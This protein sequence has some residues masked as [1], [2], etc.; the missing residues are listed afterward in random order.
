MIQASSVFARIARSRR[1]VFLAVLGSS[2]GMGSL[3]TPL[4]EAQTRD[5]TVDVL[6]NSTNTAGYNTSP[7]QPGEYQRYPERY[8]ENLQIPYRVI[9][10]S[11]VNPPDLTSAQ[12]II[13]GHKGLNL[14]TAWQ[15]AIQSAVVGGVGFVNLDSD[16]AVGNQSHIQAIF[17]ATGSIAGT[18]GESIVVPAAVQPGGATPHYIAGMQLHFLSDPAGDLIYNF[19]GD[20]ISSY[21]TATATL[22]QG[23]H[24]AVVAYIHSGAHS[25]NDPLILATTYGLGSA[26]HFGTYDYLRADRFGFN[27]GVDDL[28]WRSLV[29]AARKP[30]VI[31]AY[32]RLFSLQLD[33]NAAI[34]SQF[35][36]RLQHFWDTSLTGTVLQDGTGG[37]WKLDA[38]I[39]PDTLDPGS[40]NSTADRDLLISEI[41]AGHVKAS[42]HRNTDVYAGDLFWNS[43]VGPWS[44]SGW[45]TALNIALQVQQGNGGSDAMPYSRSN[46][47]EFWDYSNN[48]GYDLWHSLG[49]RYV[50]EIQEP[51]AVYYSTTPKTNAQRMPFRPFRIYEQPPSFGSQDETLPFFWA[52]YYTIGSRAGLPAQTFFGFSS[53][54]LSDNFRFP[55]PDVKFP[56]FSG[57]NSWSVAQSLENFQV[58]AWR[59]WSA[60]TPVTI[61]AHDENSYA[62][63]PDSERQQLISQLST[64]LNTNGVIHAF[65]EDQGDYLLARRTSTLVSGEAT[66]STIT[67]NF[68]GQATDFD[69]KLVPTKALVFYGNDNGSWVNVPGFGAGGSTIS[70]PNATPPNIL[71]STNSLNFAAVPGSNPPSQQV[72]V[73]NGGGGTLNWFATSSAQWL[74]ISPSSGVNSSLLTVSVNSTSLSAGTYSGTIALSALGATNSPQYINVSLVIGPTAI[75]VNPTSVSFTAFQNQG[76]PPTQT[77]NL[78]NTGGGSLSWTATSSVSWLTVTPTAGSAPSTLTLSANTNGLGIGTFNGTITLTSSQANNSPKTI[79]VTLT[80]IG[81][82]LG[83]NF[84]SG[85]LA[86]WAY[87][88]LGLASN[89]SVANG[90]VQYDGGGHTQIYAGNTSWTDY[91]VQASIKLAS[92]ANYPGGIRGRVNVV[93][94]GSYAVWLYPNS[95]LIRLYKTQT[96]N[97]DAGYTQ[98]GQA[99]QLFD[100][101]SYHTVGLTMQGSA[102]QVLY[103]GNVVIS[104]T[105]T[106]YA[107]G[108]IALDVSNQPISFTNIIVTGTG[109]SGSFAANPSTVNFSWATGGATPQPQSVQVTST[110]AGDLAWSATSNAPWLSVSPTTGA[111]PAGLQVSVNTSGMTAGNYSGTITLVSLAAANSPQTITAN[112]SVTTPPPV[113]IASQTAYS[114]NVGVGAAAPTSQAL[115]IQ[116]SGA[117]SYSWSVTSDS[118]WLT[119]SAASGTTPSTIQVNAN[120]VGL[121]QGTYNGNLLVTAPGLSGSPATIPVTL[122]VYGLYVA[123]DFSSN[124]LDGWAVSPLGLATNWAVVNQAVQYNGNGP[125][126]IYAGNAGWADYSVQADVKFSNL[127]NFPGGIRGRVQPGSGGSYAVWFYPGYQQIRL[128]SVSQ[129]NIDNG[130]T[131]LGTATLSYDTS[132]FHTIKLSMQGSQLNVYFDGQLMITATDTTYSHGMIALDVSNQPITYDNVVV[133]GATSVAGSLSPS[134]NSLTFIGTSGGTNPAPQNVQLQATGGGS[135][136]YSATSTASWLSVAP[137]TGTTSATLQVSANISGLPAG[138][139]N[140]TIRLASLGD[141]SSPEIIN[142]T[143]SVQ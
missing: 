20:G 56:D 33:D 135:L 119:V 83:D 7:N 108:M 75:G 98:L 16:P 18:A 2:L 123:D 80:I 113:L 58:N 68:S 128:Y 77:V 24:G 89:W 66:T 60:L 85:T 140:G 38:Y 121:N 59:F 1:F 118:P 130:F 76:N 101:S 40:A 122:T 124:T 88:P 73:S 49:V 4:A 41:Q 94:G 69:G 134:P 132:K 57:P 72:T 50:L 46:I 8:L 27:L 36:T 99:V 31:R 126:Q 63:T 22:L 139:Y 43:D 102:L 64:W 48:V 100:A 53:Q 45:L 131:T 5:L 96:W 39:D 97:I 14:S 111:T 91:T 23:A 25:V 105:D 86:G 129:W 82:L 10:V 54:I 71:L 79:P 110:G 21:P 30:F 47:P 19:H 13:A 70:F 114:F 116:S 125:T 37:P 28:F 143:L 3:S 138:T 90:A 112:L 120:S 136:A 106:S 61:F 62:N 74:N 55:S 9:D 133:T 34:D 17:G 117:G 107:N 6:V 137:T 52:D 51:G 109:S 26:V 104:A 35:A 92:L 65:V 81:V 32:P 115:T 12:L 142:I 42:V 67:L 84:G 103:D 44:D 29:W 141:P 93:T 11:S 127:S 78:T 87:S 95:S 15:Q